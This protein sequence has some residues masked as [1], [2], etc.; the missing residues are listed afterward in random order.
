MLFRVLLCCIMLCFSVKFC[1]VLLCYATLCCVVF[2]F[3]L[4]CV[5]LCC[6]VLL[7][8]VVFCC[9]VFCYVSFCYVLLYPACCILAIYL[10]E[11]SNP[12]TN[13]V[14]H[15]SKRVIFQLLF[16]YSQQFF[17]VCRQIFQQKVRQL[18]SSKHFQPNSRSLSIDQFPLKLEIMH[19][20]VQKII[21][22]RLVGT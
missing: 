16:Y 20:T 22:L 18:V 7:S 14:R 4:C 2:C 11:I 15:Q 21:K 1:C 5:V 6:V 13:G 8:C 9:A 17:H 10:E 19:L 12:T 3:T